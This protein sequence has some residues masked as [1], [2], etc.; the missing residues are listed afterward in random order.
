MHVGIVD[1]DDLLIESVRFLLQVEPGVQSVQVFASAEALLETQPWPQLD[2][3]LVDLQLPGC[4]G[5]ELIAQA[6]ARQ[7]TLNCLAF[8]GSDQLQTVFAAIEAGACG[9]LLKGLGFRE[10]LSALHAIQAGGAPMTPSIARQ[11]LL[12]IQNHAAV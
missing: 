12:Q 4:S 2:V 3:L 8:T 5:V 7:P 6:K 11:V 10:L 9:Y 1:D